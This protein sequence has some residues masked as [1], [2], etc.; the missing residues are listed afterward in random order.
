MACRTPNIHST[1]K[2]KKT[3][4]LTRS[5]VLWS[6][7]LD[8]TAAAAQYPAGAVSSSTTGSGEFPL[9]LVHEPKTTPSI[10]PHSMIRLLN[11]YEGNSCSLIWPGEFKVDVAL[12]NAFCRPTKVLQKLLLGY[13]LFPVKKNKKFSS[14]LK[15]KIKPRH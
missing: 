12:F 3:K 2:R 4:V 8:H 7:A 5:M 1:K 14:E 10:S 11:R 9:M 13:I 6:Q 15:S